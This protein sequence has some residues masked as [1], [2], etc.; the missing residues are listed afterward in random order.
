VEL[1]HFKRDNRTS[2]SFFLK[3]F[4][5]GH[6][7][8]LP[9]PCNRH[10]VCSYYQKTMESGVRKHNWHVSGKNEARVQANWSIGTLVTGS[11]ALGHIRVF[12]LLCLS[13]LFGLVFLGSCFS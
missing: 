10:S 5:T 1:N 11:C 3:R 12:D 4:P 7:A 6:D 9:F 8:T 2:P 13:N